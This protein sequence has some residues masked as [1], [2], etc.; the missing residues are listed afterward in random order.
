MASEDD[1]YMV[2]NEIAAFFKRT[3]VRRDTCDTLAMNLVGGKQVTPVAIQGTCSYTVYAGQHLEYA[4]QFRLKSL[5]VNV[6]VAALARQIYGTLVPDISFQQQLGEDSATGGKEPLLVY[7]MS[8]ITGISRLDF[9]LSRGFPENSPKNKACRQNL[10]QDVARF[11]VLAWKAPQPVAAAYRDRMA[12]TFE[13]E[14]QTLLIALPERFRPVIRSTLAALPGILSLPM[15]LIHKDFGDCNIIVE[16]ESCHLVG[17]IDWAEAEI[18][19]FGTNFHSVQNLMSKF[20][21]RNGWIRYEDYDDLVHCFWETLGTEIG[22]LDSEVIRNIRAA[23][24]LG[25]L[26]SRGFTSR[27]A[28]N[29]E[30]VP[31]KDDDSGR[32]NML[33]LDGLLTNKATRFEGLDEQS[34][35]KEVETK[36]E[37]AS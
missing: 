18:G 25:L 2:E 5:G 4:V 34:A 6:E 28:T 17:V 13:K 26:R 8:R 21:L 37:M 16:N 11:F 33:I 15:T 36:S 19:P 29:P 14:L 1:T 12:N 30:P 31:I 23:R 24:V 10:V 20:H 3:T 7:V 9:I 32:Y 27:L 35:R 22:G